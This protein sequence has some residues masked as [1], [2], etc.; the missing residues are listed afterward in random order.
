M[1]SL[2]NETIAANYNKFNIENGT[3]GRTLI[4]KLAGT[5]LTHANLKSVEN[6][7]TTAHGNGG[8]GDSAFVIAGFGTAD[9]TAFVSGTTDTVYFALQG[10]G[11]FTPATADM[12]IDGLTITVE[13]V[14]V[15]GR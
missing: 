3:N 7:L 6:Y 8:T 4:V 11:D 2:L 14:L 13:A 15:Q 1:P 5:N 9:G 10:T 12:A